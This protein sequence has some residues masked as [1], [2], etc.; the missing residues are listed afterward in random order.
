MRP[1]MV[2]YLAIV[3]AAL[4][5]F[6]LG[7]IWHTVLYKPWLVALGKT[8]ANVERQS[9]VLPFLTTFVAL[10]VMAWM[11]AGIMAHMGQ[12]T[13]RGGMITGFLVWLGFVITV[14]G[15]THAFTGAKPMLTLIDGGYWL[16]AL[17]IM[18]AVIGAFGIG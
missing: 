13:I 15:V 11:L 2:N 1:I 6:G 7:M 18:G 5:G 10:L 12:V 8:K 14:I 17:L 4:A 3:I 16:A 9:V